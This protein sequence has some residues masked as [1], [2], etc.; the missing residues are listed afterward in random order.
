VTNER[1]D[2]LNEAIGTCRDGG[3][4]FGKAG[5]G[6]RHGSLVTCTAETEYSQSDT[7]GEQQGER[8]QYSDREA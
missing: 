4:D 6:C 3:G 1:E 2:R 7:Q 5:V 8:D